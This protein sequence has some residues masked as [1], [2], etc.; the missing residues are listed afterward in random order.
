[1]AQWVQWDQ[2]DLRVLLALENL[3]VLKVLWDQEV[4]WNQLDLVVQNPLVLREVLKIL[5][6]Q[7]HQVCLVLLLV[8]GVLLDRQALLVHLALVVQL[9]LSHQQ[10]QHILFPQLVHLLLVVPQC[11]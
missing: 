1:M 5:V 9:G 2:L 7:F 4:L 3:L 10:D 11:R 6:D 8:H